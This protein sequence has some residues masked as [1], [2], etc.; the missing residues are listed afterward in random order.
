MD[1][2]HIDVYKQV[3]LFEGIAE[4]DLE[5][6]LNCLGARIKTY[7]KGDYIL[8]AG[9]EVRSIG[10]IVTGTVEIVKEDIL[11]RRAL[12]AGLSPTDIFGEAQACAGVKKSHA[13]VLATS[14]AEICFTDYSRVVSSCTSA[15]GFHTKLI[16]NMLRLMARKN[17]Y[18][19]KKMDYLGLKGMREKLSAY[20]LDQS[21]ASASTRFEIPFNREELADFLGVD[22]SALSR[23][24]GRMRD[25]G[26]I[27]FTKKQFELVNIEGMLLS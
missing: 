6:M 16:R 25:E 11:G 17:L 24:L 3:E 19:N 12:V 13:S 2:K 27:A 23:E 15:C 7:Q 8:S 21:A 5:T 14:R 18:L 26:L 1:K 9:D 20:L 22:R 10:I 4:N